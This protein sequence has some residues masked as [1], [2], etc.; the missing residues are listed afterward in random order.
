MRI[1]ILLSIFMSGIAV[2]ADQ[3]SAIVALNDFANLTGPR[4]YEG[5]D[6]LGACRVLIYTQNDE[7]KSRIW[8]EGTFQLN[9]GATLGMAI[10]FFL[11]S[12]PQDTVLHEFYADQTTASVTLTVMA[13]GREVTMTVKLV[14]SGESIIYIAYQ[15]PEGIRTCSDLRRLL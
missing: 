5:H 9:T 6:S 15:I 13:E 1:L 11:S 14:K 2:A 7:R 8:V 3:R 4:L 12:D 10:P